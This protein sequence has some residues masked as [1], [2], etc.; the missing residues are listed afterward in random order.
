MTAKW[1][2]LELSILLESGWSLARKNQ[3]KNISFMLIFVEHVSTDA[4]KG[5]KS[6]SEHLFT[7]FT[8][9]DSLLLMLNNQVRNGAMI[10]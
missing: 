9:K 5:A 10:Q 6:Y 7:H 3:F 1:K 4:K 2:E 8:T